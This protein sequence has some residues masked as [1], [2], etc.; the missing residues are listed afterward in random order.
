MHITSWSI[1]IRRTKSL[2]CT[3]SRDITL[4]H[5]KNSASSPGTAKFLA[6]GPLFQW[7]Y[8][9]AYLLIK[10]LA[11]CA[12]PVTFLHKSINLLASL[13]YTLNR[14]MQH[15]LGLVQLFLDLHD[16][17]S[18]LRILVLHNVFFELREV[19]FRG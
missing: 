12:Q 8:Q 18:L 9:W 16:A 11:L 1:N 10:H 19:E 13:Q 5:S 4:K 3:T 17:I 2:D 6:V 7:L 14:F 15:N